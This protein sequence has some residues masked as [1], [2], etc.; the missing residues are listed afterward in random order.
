MPF[1]RTTTVRSHDNP[2]D[3]PYGATLRPL[4]HFYDPVY[5][6]ALT[7]A[8]QPLGAA[9]PRWAIGAAQPFTQPDVEEA[10]RHNHFTIVD[11][12]EALFRAVTLKTAGVDGWVDLPQWDDAPRKDAH[13]KTYW[14]T[15]FRGLG[16]VLHLVQD[17]AQPQHSRNDAHAGKPFMG[18][19]S[20]FEAYIEA[21]ARRQPSFTVLWPS[22]TAVRITSK[23]LPYQICGAAGSCVDYPTPRSFQR[24]T[25]FW[26]TAPGSAI[27]GRG[28][29][30]YSNTQFFSAGKNL[31]NSDYTSPPNSVASY[32]VRTVAPTR[33]DGTAPTTTLANAAVRLYERTAV[34]DNL[35]PGFTAANVPLTSVS[36]WDEFLSRAALSP[37]FTLTRQNYDAQADLLLPR[38][39]AYSAGMLSFIFRGAMAIGVPEQG[40]YGIIDHAAFGNT[41]AANGFIGF[42]KI[43]LSLSNVSAV[44]PSG[45][46]PEPMPA[47]ALITALKFHRNLC[48][49]DTLDGE[50]TDAAAYERCRSP[51]EEVVVSEPLMAQSVPAGGAPF[52]FT[53]KKHLP[54][55][56]W[57]V[58]L[59]VVYRGQLG[60]EKD[61]VVVATRDITEPTFVTSSND[62]DYVQLQGQCYKPAAVE[63]NATLWSQ[64]EPGC[65]DPSGQMKVSSA[66]ANVA[67]PIRYTF[68]TVAPAIVEM[69]SATT[70]NRLPP[71]RFSRFAVLAD[72]EVPLRL[73]LELAD[74][75]MQTN[76][77]GM[78]PVDRYVTQ[79][80]TRVVDYY[81]PRR[82]V[83]TFTGFTYMIDADH[84]SMASACRSGLDPLAGAAR[85]PAPVVITGWN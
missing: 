64:L 81:V 18:H 40:I 44:P 45:S 83:N 21:R 79:M 70:D 77:A 67:L 61:A 5:D 34:I 60:S 82:G 33:W 27:G 62:T 75:S 41:D 71:R 74:S 56:A 19:A 6:R 84:R 8:G 72:P 47:G 37:G 36:A 31:G 52:T 49:R 28:L 12:K 32:T 57:D 14:A 78:Q 24:Y 22:F 54:V 1:A 55:N 16:D 25:D 66:C 46:G 26:S 13:R 17:M 68:G 51:T 43:K 42:G 29:A 48:Y 73:K 76:L 50:I 58:V 30:D 10:A 59:Q 23:P 85:R 38:A 35:E 15:V 53:F 20:T 7:A 9:S 80:E 4:N 63:A 69:T 65:R 3:D 11:V 39:V 2:Q